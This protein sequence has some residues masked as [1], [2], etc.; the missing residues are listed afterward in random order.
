MVSALAVTVAFTRTR[1]AWTDTVTVTNN[2]VTTGTLDLEVGVDGQTWSDAS[3][4]SNITLSGLYPGGPAVE[5]ASV[6]WLRNVSS[7]DTL[8]MNLVAEINP[9]ASIVPGPIANRAVLYIEIYRGA[10]VEASTSLNLWEAGTIPIA[11]SLPVDPAGRAYGIRAWLDGSAL[12]EWQG[13]TV[14]YTLV[15]TGSQP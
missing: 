13:Q 1:A 6:F 7:P 10:T 4:A 9:D 8:T 5:N 2:I 11:T 15:F 3:A 14:T 12:D